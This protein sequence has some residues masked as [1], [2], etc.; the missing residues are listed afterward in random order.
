MG[1]PA[2]VNNFFRV[3]TAEMAYVLGYWYADGYMYIKPGTK[4]H[5]VEFASIDRGH[6][7]SIASIIGGNS[8]IRKVDANGQC[9]ELTYCSKEMYRD[10]QAHG[11][12]PHKSRTLVFPYIPSELLPHYVRGFADGDG[13]LSW[14]EGKPILQLYSASPRFL[15]DLAVAVEQA[16]GIPAPNT[17][18]NRSLWTIKWSTIRAKCLAMWLYIDN[19]GLALGEKVAIAARF[20][21]W[22]PKKAP[23]RGTITDEMRLRFPDYLPS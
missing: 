2:K 3:W 12:T 7:E 1:R 15:V 21:E 19:P 10:L 16:T 20:L 9:Y 4:A 6:L 8:L 23:H 11:G 5:E 22:Q 13:T 18:A 17:V 14:N